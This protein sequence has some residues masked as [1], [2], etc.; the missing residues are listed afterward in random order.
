VLD[1]KQRL[2]AVYPHVVEI[3]LRPAVP[4]GDRA[5]AAVRRSLAPLDA[6]EA[7]WIE[8]TSQPP[9]AAERDVLHQALAHAGGGRG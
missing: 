6:V 7:F 5:P 2:T 1:A 4:A 9:T 3:D 8:S